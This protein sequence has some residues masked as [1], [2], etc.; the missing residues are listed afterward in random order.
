MIRSLTVGVPIFSASKTELS[1]RLAIFNQLAAK[2]S[3]QYQLPVRTI[4]LTLPPPRLHQDASPGMLRSVLDS[5]RELAH[6]AGARWYCLPIDLFAEN[7]REGFLEEVQTLLVKD[8]QLFVNLISA[9]EQAISMAG[10]AEASRFIL[11]LARRS[12]NGIDNF[13]VGISAACPAGTPF[14]PFARHDGDSLSFSIA[15]ETTGLTLSLAEKA[16]LH[17]WSLS[18]FQQALILQLSE[19]MRNIE[20]FGQQLSAETGFDYRGLDAS[21]APFP[22][23]KTSV[24]SI[25]ECMGP[26]PVGSHG[27]VF[28]TSV[29]TDAIKLAAVHAQ[30]RLAG[31]NGVMFSVLEDNGL[32]NANNLRALSLEKLALFSTVCGCGIDMVPVPSSMFSEDISGLILDI[33]ALAVRLKKPL[34]VRLLPI[35]NKVVN[36]YTQLN[37]DFL[38]DSRVMDPGISASK[39]PLSDE[40]WRYG[41]DRNKG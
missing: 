23:G 21:L 14:F 4:R 37:L 28:M 31:F 17:C 13:R 11:N 26:T 20:L 1:S 32:T 2:L 12:S 34:G 10:A 3:E 29:L 40:V 6:N 30:A 15:L 33:A 8:S 9:T 7:T 19:L 35:P 41:A 18:E 5:V 38:C 22:D 25:I 24:A 39:A 27:T 16:R 36:E